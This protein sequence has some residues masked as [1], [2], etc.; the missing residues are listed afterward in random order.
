M[1][2]NAGGPNARMIEEQQQFDMAERGRRLTAFKAA[3]DGKALVEIEPGEW[4]YVTVHP[5]ADLA[6]TV[7]EL[8]QERLERATA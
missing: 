4:R 2:K 3:T 7:A 1:Y 6:Q 8:E 5:G